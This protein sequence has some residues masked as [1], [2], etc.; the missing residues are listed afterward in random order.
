MTTYDETMPG[1][2]WATLEESPEDN[3]SQRKAE[4]RSWRPVD[5]TDVLNG[6]YVTPEPTVG[7]R[8]DGEGLFYPGRTHS[9]VGESEGGKTWL[10]LFAV[11][12]ELRR[13]CGAVYIDFEDDE[14]GVVG[15]LLAM[16]VTRDEIRGH[17]AY[18]HPEEKLEDLDK[19]QRDRGRSDLAAVMEDLKPTLV[20]LD[21][22]TEAMTLFGL[23]I[24][25]NGDAARF[26]RSLS[27]W[28]AG[29]GAAVVEI[30]HVVKNAETRGRYAIGGVHKL[31]AITGAAYTLDNRTPF[32][33]GRTGKSAVMISK[34][35]PGQL[36]RK[37]LSR[38]AVKG[39]WYCD[40]VIESH[41]AGAVTA[42]LPVPV[43]GGEGGA[44]R[45]KP[46]IYMDRVAKALTGG[47]LSK[48][49]L[50]SAIGGRAEY[51]DN[52]LEQLIADGY[53]SSKTPHGL[54]KSY[55]PPREDQ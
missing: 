23:E 8:D 5:L 41:G 31:N 25:D 44:S 6:T 33:I 2:P 36:R 14:H 34:D 24:K 40:L 55:T 28:L 18:L 32:G 19:A 42:S 37:G 53:V 16:G 7:A 48:R 45:W 20:I 3:G 38:G 29:Y 12:R 27:K 11:A 1:D 51:V 47:P 21:G 50:R 30:D 17:F 52:G 22:V 43:E 4:E 15:R 39:F 46:T 10:A 54:L 26:A 49:A 35:R 9:I 13:A